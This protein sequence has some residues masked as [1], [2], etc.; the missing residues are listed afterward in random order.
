MDARILQTTPFPGPSASVGRLEALLLP[1]PLSAVSA[2]IIVA[3]F[4]GWGGWL[5]RRLRGNDRTTSLEE[6]AGFVLAT[7]LTAAL[8][9]GLGLAGIG[10]L[11]TLRL[12]GIGIVAPG[13]T[14]AL[15]TLHHRGAGWRSLFASLCQHR[16]HLDRAAM[17]C[18]ALI[19]IGLGLA[20]LGPP[21]DADSLHYHLGVPLQWLRAGA[22]Q[23]MPYW[24][25][26]RLAGLGETLI[27]LGLAL[28]TDILGAVLNVV[29]LVFILLAVGNGVRRPSDRPFAIL[30]VI[31][32]PV[33]TFLVTTQKPQ[34][35]PTAA[36]LTAVVLLRRHRHQL[37]PGLLWLGFSGITFAISCKHSFFFSGLFAIAIGL[38]AAFRQRCLGLAIAILVLSMFLF[39]APVLIRNILF[40]G[41]PIS[42]M[43]ERVK[44]NPDQAVTAFAWYLRNFGIR[45]TPTNLAQLPFL[46]VVPTDLGGVNGILGVGVFAVFLSRSGGRTDRIMLGASAA[47]TLLVLAFGPWG[48]RFLFE[49]YLWM[50][51]AI[52]RET[53]RPLA[54]SLTVCLSL[55]GILTLGIALQGVWTLTPGALDAKR[56]ERVMVD[57][58]ADYQLIRWLDTLLPA[59][60]VVAGIYPNHAQIP[61]AF[62]P[63]D[64]FRMLESAHLPES[65]KRRRI[66]ELLDHFGVDTVVLYSVDRV[67][68]FT[69]LVGPATLRLGV[70]PLSARAGRN[71]FAE[72]FSLE[73]TVVRY[74]S[75][76]AEPSV[77][78]AGVSGPR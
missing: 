65:E 28:G 61:R 5:A 40:Y 22:I 45:H 69:R 44:P 18:S 42:P 37:T 66:V 67:Y 47:M 72:S 27:L 59:D 75:S 30:L 48:T 64:Y 17:V 63:T 20:A 26:A 23:P 41:D 52:A 60:C 15:W 10:H 4:W 12:L 21:T 8:V 32:V 36:M 49:P 11:Q 43:L 25:H 73:A 54:R 13:F 1:G 19:M 7:A 58:A 34:L 33:L 3:A 16:N 6:S 31:S 71:P 46:L 70:L 62:I 55:Q 51:V 76:R 50:V 57:V 68:P 24:L 14:I 56:R 35:F 39:P 9:H 2:I 74:D 53:R 29:G 77:K 38:L 78:D